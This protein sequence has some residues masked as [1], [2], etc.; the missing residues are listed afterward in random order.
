MYGAKRFVK[1]EKGQAMVEYGLI[2]ALVAV[3][4]IVV[5]VALTGGLDSIF[6]GTADVLNDP[7]S[8]GGE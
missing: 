7:G 2:I 8:A 5:L 6:Q 1:D 4:L 3:V